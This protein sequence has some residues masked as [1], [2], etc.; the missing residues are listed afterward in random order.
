[1]TA[2]FRRLSKST[3][4]TII[5]VFF[6]LAILAGFAMQ[7]IRSVGSGGVGLK[8]G[9]LAEVGSQSVTERELS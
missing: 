5:T 4:G 8:A 6:L 1:M 9:T 2:L 7:D 3:I